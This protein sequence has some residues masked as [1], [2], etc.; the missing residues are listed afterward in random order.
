MR[1]PPTTIKMGS[2]PKSHPRQIAMTFR[3][4]TTTM[5]NI[6]EVARAAT[7][8]AIACFR[9]ALLASTI[10]AMNRASETTIKPTPKIV[11]KPGS[12]NSAGWRLMD[13]LSDESLDLNASEH[14]TMRIRDRAAEP[15]APTIAP[16]LMLP[17]FLAD[18]TLPEDIGA[19]H[20]GHTAALSDISL[21]HSGHRI[22]AIILPFF[23]ASYHDCFT[24]GGAQNRPAPLR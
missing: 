4:K 20:D 18:A 12:V 11:N 3:T 7:L 2:Q 9:V 23:C 5:S 22:I 24:G 8:R 15:I 21:P 17:A 14:Q 10:P 16:V 1:M 13:T 19:P 6:A